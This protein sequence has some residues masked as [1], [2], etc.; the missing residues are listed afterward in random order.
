VNIKKESKKPKKE[1]ILEDTNNKHLTKEEMLTLELNYQTQQSMSKDCMIKERELIL[2]THQLEILTL[3]QEVIKLKLEMS[4]LSAV[5]K[6]KELENVK[7]KHR[8][9]TLSITEKYELDEKWGFNPDTGKL[10]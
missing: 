3:K 5:E 10:I 2:G 4:K 7:N 6:R 8:K 1:L 9:F